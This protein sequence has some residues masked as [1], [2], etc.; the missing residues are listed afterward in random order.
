MT[1]KMK[2]RTHPKSSNP[3][4]GRNNNTVNIIVR[5]RL[6]SPI[7]KPHN[8]FLK[9]P[10]VETNLIKVNA[11]KMGA[12]IKGWVSN[13]SRIISTLNSKIEYGFGIK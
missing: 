9:R 5:I 6:V 7:Y 8:R 13:N 1:N 2:M 4:I 12:K 10:I 11:Q 3:P